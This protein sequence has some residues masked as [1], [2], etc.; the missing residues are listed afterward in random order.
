MPSHSCHHRRGGIV[1]RRKFIALLGGAAA[2]LR[3]WPLRRARAAG[4]GADHRVPRRGDACGL[5]P[6]GRRIC[7]AAARARLDRGPHRRDRVS[8]GEGRSERF[9]EIAAEFVRRKV[10]VIVTGGKR[11]ARGKAGDVD[12][13]DRVR[14]GD[15]PGRQ[16]PG[17]QPGATGRQRHRPVAPAAPILPA[18]GSNSCARSSPVSAGWRSWPM[19]AIPAPCWRW[20]RSK[21]R[22]AGSASRSSRS[23]S[24]ERRIS[25][26]PS[27]RSRAERTRSTSVADP[28]VTANRVRINTLALAAR[29]PTMLRRSG[30]TS[31]REV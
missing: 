7:A 25:H 29:L 20:A 13:P 28:L 2:A 22:P 31:K 10:D 24:G 12:H 21:L 9:A 23:K 11:S 5:R 19:S 16:R 3:A 15:R 8:L 17:R 1:K 30:A 18:S 14:D 4:Q 27:T 26:P 6:M